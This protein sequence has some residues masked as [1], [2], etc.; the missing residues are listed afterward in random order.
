MEQFNYHKLVNLKKR[1]DKYDCHISKEILN[2]IKKHLIIEKEKSRKKDEE[3]RS[4]YQYERIE[5]DECGKSLLRKSLY[6]HK[7][8]LHS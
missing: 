3:R 4:T 2:V 1:F 5:C 6:V 8:R 7:E